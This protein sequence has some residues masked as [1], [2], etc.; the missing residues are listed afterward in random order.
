M[1]RKSHDQ[2]ITTIVLATSL[3]TLSLFGT[4]LF[5]EINTDYKPS[6]AISDPTNPGAG[7]TSTLPV[8]TQPTTNTS[9]S[10]V[11]TTQT[12]VTPIISSEAIVEGTG[13]TTT[14]TNTAPTNSN[15]STPTQPTQSPVTTLPV[16]GSN[17]QGTAQVSGTSSTNTARSGGLEVGIAF[18]ALISIF[19]GIYYYK[20][21]GDRK[22]SFKTTEQ[23]IRFRR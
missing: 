20:S 18:I 23:K 1:S 17:T 16:T 7:A 15:P 12:P 21:E 2:K 11:P 4:L 22:S 13:Q 9:S 14:T 8:A 19:G 10:G 5:S 6:F 3:V